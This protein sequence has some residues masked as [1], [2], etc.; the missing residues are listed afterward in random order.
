MIIT[1]TFNTYWQIKKAC[2]GKPINIV[3]MEILFKGMNNPNQDKELM[4]IHKAL[5]GYYDHELTQDEWGMLARCTSELAKQYPAEEDLLA[6]IINILDTQASKEE[7]H[8]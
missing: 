1:D 4:L 7:K 8:E 6:E 2:S 5:R 3:L